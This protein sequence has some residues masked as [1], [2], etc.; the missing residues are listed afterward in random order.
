MTDSRRDSGAISSQ[1]ILVDYNGEFRQTQSQATLPTPR[2]QIKTSDSSVGIFNAVSGQG[3][4][5]G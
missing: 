1:E 4:I 5:A 3:L 2:E